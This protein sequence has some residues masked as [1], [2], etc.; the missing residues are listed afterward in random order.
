MN[1]NENATTTKK[2]TYS[3]PKKKK[4]QLA[5]RPNGELRLLNL[6]ITQIGLKPATVETLQNGKINKV[7][8][9]LVYRKSEL[10]KIQKFNKK[11]LLDVS[12]RIKHLNL[13]FRP[14]ADEI[15]QSVKDSINNQVNKVK[16]NKEKQNQNR[17]KQNPNNKVA[18]SNNKHQPKQNERV[19]NAKPFDP[20]ANRIRVNS[21]GVVIN[22]NVKPK[23][24]RI[25]KSQL[26]GTSSISKRLDSRHTKV[27][28]P[29]PSKDDLIKFS[30][31]DKYGF[32]DIRGKVVIPAQ[33]DDAFNFKEGFSCV[34]KNGK[35][36]YINRKNKLVIPYQ[37][38]LAMSF[39]EGLACV[40]KGEKTGYIDKDGEI[41]F[42][43]KF[44]AGTAFEEGI[45]RVKVEG[46]WGVLD[47]ETS[48]LRMI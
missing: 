21:R 11:H 22:D 19:Q 24:Q 44:D 38:D 15:K 5:Y 16:Q 39:S 34:E 29:K 20:R 7:I 27:K 46:K 10:Y 13:E 35:Y 6:P 3:K 47:K 17:D 28:L 37:F 25:P 40:T 45:A 42:E 1:G 41:K 30:K 14:E 2:R 9:L 4:K 48:N 43:L 18:K 36:G 33:Y 32:K 12:N 31:N 8:E 23:Q 26:E